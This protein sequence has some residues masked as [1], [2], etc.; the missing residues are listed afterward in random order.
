M[1]MR[2]RSS[3]WERTVPGINELQAALEVIRSE[4][5]ATTDPVEWGT[6]LVIVAEMVF[7]RLGFAPQEQGEVA[8]NIGTDDDPDKM[9]VTISFPLQENEDHDAA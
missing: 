4:I 2:S 7:S 3:R 1:Q 5:N 6:A 9:S 8:I